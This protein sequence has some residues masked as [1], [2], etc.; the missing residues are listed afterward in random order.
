M[1]EITEILEKVQSGEDG[2]VDRLLE[3]VYD[4][5][6]RLAAAKLAREPAGQTL[7][8]TALVHEA[9]LKIAGDDGA[10]RF[11]NRRHFFAATAEAMRRILVDRARRRQRIRHGGGM[12][13][14]DQALDAVTTDVPDEKILAVHEALEALQAEDPAKADIVKLRYFVGLNSSEIAETL[15]VSLRSVERHWS[16]AGAWLMDWIQRNRDGLPKEN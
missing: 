8:A 16:Y 1:T 6:R 2:A 12:E 15:G 7:Q 13:R 5:L 11:E 3:R 10:P 9:W 14:V 4:E